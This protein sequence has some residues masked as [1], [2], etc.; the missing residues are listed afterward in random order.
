MANGTQLAIRGITYDV[1]QVDKGYTLLGPRGARYRTMRNQVRPEMMFLVY[2]DKF[3]P[4]LAMRGIWLTDKE[5]QLV[6]ARRS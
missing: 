1:V 6:V 4:V 5:G 2:E 3:G